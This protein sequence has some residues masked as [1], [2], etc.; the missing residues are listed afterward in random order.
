MNT[1]FK[2]LAVTSISLMTLI[3]SCTKKD[4]EPTPHDYLTA[5]QWKMS[6]I[7]VDPPI[8][9]LNMQISDVWNYVPQCQKDNLIT[10]EP[11]GTVIED[12]GASKCVPGD[13]Q[14]TNDGTWSITTD[15][16]TLIINY[17]DQDPQMASIITLDATTLV[18]NAN[19]KID[20]EIYQFDV[21]ATVT[22]ILQ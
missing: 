9:I 15:G 1:I 4:N 10:F 11:D 17:P 16:K 22:F 21:N 5:G 2:L 8:E 13:P 14:V 18:V 6:G 7:I 3:Y 19:Q 12:E 20:F